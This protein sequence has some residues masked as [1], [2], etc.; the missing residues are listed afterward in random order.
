MQPHLAHVHKVIIVIQVDTHRS[1]AKYKMSKST[2]LL[3]KIVVA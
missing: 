1:S 2:L 3:N